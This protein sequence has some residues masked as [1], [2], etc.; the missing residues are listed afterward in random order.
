MHV[1]LLQDIPGRGFQGDLIEVADGYA[2]SFLFP[3]ALAVLA[4]PE[5]LAKRASEEGVARQAKPSREHIAAQKR[6]EKLEGQECVVRVPA[7]EGGVLLVEPFS[8][9]DVVKLIKKEMGIVVSPKQLVAFE[10]IVQAGR[11]RVA[12]D[13]GSGFE[14]EITIV[15]E[16][17]E[18]EA[19][20]LTK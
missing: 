15:V 2:E 10:P 19:A 6:A 11:V 14:A 3:Q 13:V 9:K 4:T 20:L 1:I 12:V 18:A 8:S 17:E 16:G 7:Q 5:V